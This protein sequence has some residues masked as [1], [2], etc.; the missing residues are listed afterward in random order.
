M[1]ACVRKFL[2]SLKAVYCN[3]PQTNGAFFLL[4]A[5][6]GDAMVLKSLTNLRYK[7]ARPR[8]LRTCCKLVGCGRVLIALILDSSTCTP[9]EDTTKPKKTSLSTPN[10]HFSRLA[11]RRSFRRAC[12]T[13]LR[14]VA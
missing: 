11:Y 4:K 1:G 12:N 7:P 5:C 8:K 13:V 2:S 10:L 14:W 9:L 3:G 6:K